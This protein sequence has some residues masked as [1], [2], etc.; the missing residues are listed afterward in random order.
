[1]A[2]T[3]D[4]QAIAQQKTRNDVINSSPSVKRK[5]KDDTH[6]SAEHGK[7]SILELHGYKVGKAIGKGSYATVREAFS[8]KHLTNV[9]I[10]IIS[11]KRAPREYLYKFLPRE[12]EVVKIL[13]NPNLVI[14]MQCIETTNRVYLVMEH[15][16]GGDLLDVVRNRKFI[17]EAQAAVW[18]AQ[19]V[20]GIEYC[21]SQGVVHRDLKCENILLDKHNNLKITDFGFAR[22]RMKPVDGKVPLSQTYCGSYAYA[23]PEILTGTPYVGQ[24]ADIWSMGVILFVMVSM[25]RGPLFARGGSKLGDHY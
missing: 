14:F 8:H 9:A 15:A 20:G 3:G 6:A 10:K 17:V 21:H 19:L 1:M 16:S 2:D 11:K 12:I 7:F 23:P 18:F 4:T 13:R 25:C 24:I 22:D 5:A